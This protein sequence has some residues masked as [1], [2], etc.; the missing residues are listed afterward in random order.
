MGVCRYAMKRIE[1]SV[2]RVERNDEVEVLDTILHEIAHALSDRDTAV[3]EHGGAS[4]WRSERG[5]C[6][7][8]TPT[9]H[10]GAGGRAAA[11]ATGSSIAIAGDWRCLK[12]KSA[13][14]G[15]RKALRR[16]RG[17]S[18]GVFLGTTTSGSPAGSWAC[19][20]A[21][22]CRNEFLKVATGRDSSPV[23]NAT[24]F[25][26]VSTMVSCRVNAATEVR[27]K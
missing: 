14:Q 7:A 22:H 3:T 20:R 15:V 5:R 23:A 17:R 21:C 19:Q 8:A 2:H 9:C 4:A 6:V 26:T 1:L 25:V 13:T 24:A 10:W 16:R 27:W 11:D 18:L 12:A